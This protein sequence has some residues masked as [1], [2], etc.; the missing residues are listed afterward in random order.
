MKAIIVSVGTELTSGQTVDTNSAFL[1]RQLAAHG[2]STAAHLTVG[3]E[4][5]DVAA[6]ICQAAGGA[7]LVIV[8]GGL[9]PTEDDL[10]RQAL[11]AVLGCELVVDEPSLR[12]IEE[13]FALRNRPMN[14]VNRVQA[15]V[16]AKA[17]AI[18]NKVGTAPGIAA[19]LGQ[20]SIFVVP[21]VPS[22]MEWMFRNAIEPTLQDAPGVIQQRIIHTFGAG[23]SDVGSKIVDLMKRG[24]NP[25]VGTTVAAGMV[26]IRIL[27]CAQTPEAAKAIS[28]PV[29]DE[30]RRRLGELV[31][32][33][34]G[35]TM[36]GAVGELLVR[37]KQT[38][39]TAESC[40][41]GLVGK[42]I[43]DVPGSTRYYSG[44]LVTYSNSLKMQLAGVGEGLLIAHGAVS[45]EVAAAL[46]IGCRQR[47]GSD[48]A[49]S[50]TGIAGPG[51]GTPAK[52]VGLVWIALAGP[53]GVKTLRQFFPGP[54]E[55]VR[56]RTALAAMN[57]LRLELLSGKD[58]PA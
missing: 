55:T 58:S 48:W 14:A 21:G 42:L 57:M 24:A 52:P 49:I 53:S 47:L 26:S 51:G 22:E 54:R 23:E 20:A 3:D 18:P 13:F 29:A 11:A 35:S 8:S 5:A 33:E 32:G 4:L 30:V 37:A 2:I 25:L 56:L 43:T 17:A 27:S 7:E 19:K 9:G 12:Q 50:I 34:G 15:M 10:T 38:V 44:G 46:A 28:D 1:S 36:A 39:S 31:V 45:E 6:A 16:P 40:T 41:G